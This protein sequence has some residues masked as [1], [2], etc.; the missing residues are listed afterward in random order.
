MTVKCDCRYQ[1]DM[2]NLFKIIKEN[3]STVDFWIDAVDVS[4]PLSRSLF[5]TPEDVIEKQADTFLSEARYSIPFNCSRIIIGCEQSSLKDVP[6]KTYWK[7][8]G[9]RLYKEGS[10]V[11]VIFPPV[12]LSASR[13]K[14]E[15]AVSVEQKPSLLISKTTA[16]LLRIYSVSSVVYPLFSFYFYRLLLHGLLT[17]WIPAKQIFLTILTI[18]RSF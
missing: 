8:L 18:L 17:L 14:R 9:S 16:K 2:N 1:N 11:H 13:L 15:G 7:A 10:P 4:D 12:M 5:H 6:S 3:L